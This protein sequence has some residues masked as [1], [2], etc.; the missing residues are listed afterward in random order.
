MNGQ[1]WLPLKQIELET[2]NLWTISGQ[3]SIL[4]REHLKK[5]TRSGEKEPPA[6]SPLLVKNKRVASREHLE[7]EFAYNHLQDTESP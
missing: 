2:L 4:K 5:T 6:F 3:D 7:D 1:I